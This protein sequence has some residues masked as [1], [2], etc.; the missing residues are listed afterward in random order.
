M[1]KII[2]LKTSHP[3]VLYVA[4]ALTALS[5]IGSIA[6]ARLVPAS[7]TQITASEE[8][9]Q[10]KDEPGVSSD[11][12][13]DDSAYFSNRLFAKVEYAQKPFN[14]AVKPKLS[15]CFNC[16]VVV[17]IETIPGKVTETA[18]PELKPHSGDMSEQHLDSYLNAHRMNAR[19]IVMD[20]SSTKANIKA[21][22]DLSLSQDASVYTNVAAYIVKVR[23]RNGHHLTVTLNTPPQQKIGDRVR[24]INERTITA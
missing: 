24:I 22:S 3:I 10:Q 17:G 13:A 21:S 20:E 8:S 23:M 16:G 7:G 12:S 15:N 1:M 6:I 4:I 2:K 5:I 9:S 19:L 14:S 18:D 11:R